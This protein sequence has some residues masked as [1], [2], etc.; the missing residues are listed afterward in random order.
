MPE[1]LQITEPFY[2]D[3]GYNIIWGEDDYLNYGCTILDVGKVTFGN[4]VSVGPGV[5]IISLDHPRDPEERSRY[6]MIGMPVNIG[7]N[8]WI[9]ANAVILGGV[10]IADNIIIGAGSVVTSD[11]IEE[12]TYVGA[13][14]RFVHR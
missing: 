3:V 5:K 10:T 4:H 12:G 7:N 6:A 9:G 1:S 8:V 13:P 11:L 14:A 2:C